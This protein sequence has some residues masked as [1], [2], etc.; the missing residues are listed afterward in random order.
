[1]PH[2]NEVFVDTLKWLLGKTGTVLRPVV[3]KLLNIYLAH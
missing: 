2:T 3:L 1:M